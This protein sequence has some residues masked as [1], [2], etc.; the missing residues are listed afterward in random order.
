MKTFFIADW[1]Y[2]HKNIIAY[3]DRPFPSVREMNESL[4]TRW[5]EAVGRDDFVYALGDMFWCKTSEAI[6]VLKS[7][8]GQKILIR[9]NHDHTNDAVFRRE[10]AKITDYDEVE[11]DDRKIVLC[12]YPISF[13][14]NHTRDGWSH[15]YGHVHNSYEYHIA[16]NTKRQVENLFEKPC[17]M[18]NVGAMMPWMNYTPRTYEEIATGYALMKEATE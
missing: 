18:Y 1:H 4:V 13:F 15:L 11:V 10:F 9:G 2:D 14:K 7:L 8:N 16:E 5:N 17:R 6:S 12:H 3:D